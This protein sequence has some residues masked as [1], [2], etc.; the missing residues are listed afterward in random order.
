MNYVI[1]C[2]EI[3]GKKY[4][5]DATDPFCSIGIL[6]FR[7]LNNRGRLI[8]ENHSEWINLQPIKGSKAGLMAD[9]TLT[10]EGVLEGNVKE[11]Y[12]DYKNISMRK[13]IGNDTIAYTE[14][15]ES[16]YEDWNI[17]DI[18]F[19]NTDEPSK[20]LKINYSVEMENY[21]NM[22]GERIY[23]NPI[24][25]YQTESNPFKLEKREYPVNFGHPLLV[26]YLIVINIPENY[27]VEEKPNAAVVKLPEN[28][29]IYS[30]RISDS[31]KKIMVTY[32][33]KIDKDQFLPVEYLSLKEFYNHV[34]AKEKQI[35]VLKRSEPTAV[36]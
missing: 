28:G 12:Y 10:E 24:M 5:M 32:K 17:S 23:L 6:P 7:C 22:E 1:A 33:F 3:D 20:P 27:I 25:K 36:K 16:D 29:G 13:K 35:I 21:A 30:Y 18:E 11:A 15:L 19:L 8:G 9:L 26:N 14:K 34:I 4:L 2:A 31:G